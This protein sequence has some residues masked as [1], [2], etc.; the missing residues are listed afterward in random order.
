MKM[1]CVLALVAI[2]FAED[3]KKDKR[4]ANDIHIG[5]AQTPI[6]SEA[7]SIEHHEVSAHAVQFAQEALP[8][9]QQAIQEA[10]PIEQQ[11]IQY[12]QA[13]LPIAAQQTSPV[14][15]D[16]IQYVSQPPQ[17]IQYASQPIEYA[18]QPVQY[19]PQPIQYA[20]QPVQYAQEQ[21]Q[22]APQN[23]QYAAEAVAVQS[24]KQLNEPF[25]KQLILIVWCHNHIQW[26]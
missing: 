17:A 25:T 3:V 12:T 5:Y 22:F 20:S 2:G 9:V 8:F 19:A 23:V 13:A 24:P 1:V 7:A 14:Q 21:L 16:A 18:P 10:A 4:S 6:V 15:Q 26:K 11:D